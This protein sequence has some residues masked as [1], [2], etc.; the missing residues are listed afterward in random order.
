MCTNNEMK[1]RVTQTRLCT[2]KIV[3]TI[4]SCARQ[5]RRASGRF[6]RDNV[7]DTKLLFGTHPLCVSATGMRISTATMPF[8]HQFGMFGHVCVCGETAQSE[9][10]TVIGSCI[11]CIQRMQR[12]RTRNCFMFLFRHKTYCHRMWCVELNFCKRLV[13]YQKTQE[14]APRP[15]TPSPLGVNV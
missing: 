13:S 2:V 9:Q 10:W 6:A 4:T 12:E 1:T 3:R 11:S 15:V 5:V 8:G 7:T 14:N